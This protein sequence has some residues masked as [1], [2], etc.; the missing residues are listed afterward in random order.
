MKLAESVAIERKASSGRISKADRARK[1]FVEEAPDLGIEE[2]QPSKGFTSKEAARLL[3]IHGKIFI[4]FAFP[5]L[6][7]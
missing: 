6:K 4:T 5:Y 1:E 2:F 3:E 7:I